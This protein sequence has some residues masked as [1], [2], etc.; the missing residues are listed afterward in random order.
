MVFNHNVLETAIGLSLYSYEYG[1]Y[2]LLEEDETLEE[3]KNKASNDKHYTELLNSIAENSPDG[4]V[5]YYL[6]HALSDMQ[7]GI[8]MS[9]NHKR[10][11]VIFRG[12]DNYK[13]WLYNLKFLKTK[14]HDDVYVHRGFLELINT[15]NIKSKLINTIKGALKEH[16]KYKV[17]ICGHSL[18]G[19]LS[20]LF[21]YILSNEIM[22]KIYVVSFA[23]P[24]IGNYEWRKSFEER[25][26]LHHYRITMDHDLV[27][28][29][30]FFFEHVGIN[31][32]ISEEGYD[33]YHNNEY[34]WWKY[35]LFNCWSIG[36]HDCTKY[37][38]Y[39]KKYEWLKG[40]KNVKYTNHKLVIEGEV[41]IIQE[42]FD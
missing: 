19:A 39:L 14:L 33:I 7:V 13:D 25:R 22:Q 20:T 34:P 35:S 21:G 16:P 31:I 24:R 5:I 4:R 18:G 40:V 9:H 1:N 17:Y 29:L 8:T 28:A 38:K 27:T 36:N 23:S 26:N 2:E 3:F 10:I 11:F 6:N 42:K 30:P 41:S 37:Y 15:D 12:T 32:C